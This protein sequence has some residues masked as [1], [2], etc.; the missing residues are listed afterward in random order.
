MKV[1]S[2][3]LPVRVALAAGLLGMFGLAIVPAEAAVHIEGQVEAGG[4]SVA[5]STVTL[6]AGGAGEPKQLAQTKTADDGGFAFNVDETPASAVS[7]Y[8][9][10]KGGVA[11]VN[12][13][14]GDNPALA[15][16]TVL[17]SAPP[18]KVVVNEMTTVASVWTKRS[19]STARRSRVP[20]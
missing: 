14:S 7:L 8:L 1:E 11:A 20:R 19:S 12:K 16:L 17:G 4:G 5:N 15:F 2:A 18:A 3:K 10:A 9:V 6:W 13:G